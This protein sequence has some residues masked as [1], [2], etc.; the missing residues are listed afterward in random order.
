MLGRGGFG[1]VYRADLASAGGFRKSVALKVLNTDVQ[2]TAEISSRFRDEA[3]ILGLIRDRAIVHVD[4]L[5]RLGDRW[6]VVMEYVDGV[7][8]DAVVERR[9]MPAG[10]ALEVIS[11]VA[12][13][14]DVAWK[15]RGESGQPLHMLHR[16]IKPSNVQ[17]TET[18]DVKLLDFGVARADFAQREAV[19]HSLAFG[20]VRY[21]SPERMDFVDSAAGDIYALGVVLFELVTG[22]VYGKA[23]GIPDRHT[24]RVRER[25]DW[26]AEQVRPGGYEV[27]RLVSR[28]LDYEAERRPSARDVE[29]ACI[30]LVRDLRDVP[31][32]DWCEA[33]VPALKAA[34]PRFD[35]AE[36]TNSILVESGGSDAIEGMASGGRPRTLPTTGT[37]L[38]IAR[39]PDPERLLAE[40]RA[41]RRPNRLAPPAPVAPVTPLPR[42][43]PAPPDSPLPAPSSP[44]PSPA[45]PSLPAPSPPAS[46]PPVAARA[47]VRWGRV[48]AGGAVGGLLLLLAG[49][50][51]VAVATR[52]TAEEPATP[53]R[54]GAIPATQR[55]DEGDLDAVLAEP[56]RKQPRRPRADRPPAPKPVAAA[57]APAPVER[58]APAVE[59]A[60]AREA[61]AAP[62]P[63]PEPAAVEAAPT[64]PAPGRVM[65]EGDAISVVIERDGTTW[66]VPAAP[67]A[68]TVPPG[69]YTGVARFPDARVPIARVSVGEGAR[70]V[71]QCDPMMMLC[72]Q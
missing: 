72:A 53:A 45:A 61:V 64:G 15:T 17:L 22:E 23:V 30:D 24:R 5:V 69:T 7:S 44:A 67:G 35:D 66:T 55:A 13:A 60:P 59:A 50:G 4:G 71:L 19:T 56:S 2:G 46:P 42:A 9:P 1:T 70:V 12:R 8:L 3:R 54:L 37:P 43:R 25:V 47:S 49:L 10:P 26:L 41:L 28:M 18:G 34:R 58:V 14:L 68:V 20:S 52:S 63:A 33:H 65:Y 27:G 16:D 32:R 21:M 39:P 62:A 11:E 38:P 31:L 36:F 57:P 29:R 51:V 48:A 40:S 6:A